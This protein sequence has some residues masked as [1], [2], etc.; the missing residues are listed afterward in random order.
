MYFARH[1]TFCVIVYCIYRRIILVSAPNECSTLF[2]NMRF[3]VFV[4]L[5]SFR[6]SSIDSYPPIDVPYQ[7]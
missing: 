7:F 4:T 2:N 3:V 6:A 5:G 1:M